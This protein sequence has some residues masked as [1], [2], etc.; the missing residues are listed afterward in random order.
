MWSGVDS[1]A[2]IFLVLLLAN[3]TFLVLGRRCRLPLL[4]E[5]FLL[6]ILFFMNVASISVGVAVGWEDYNLSEISEFA[7]YL[8]APTAFIVTYLAMKLI[9]RFVIQGFFDRWSERI[10]EPARQ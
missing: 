4:V 10:H 3:I 8:A 5:K 2:L 9:G 7:D 1:W 6:S